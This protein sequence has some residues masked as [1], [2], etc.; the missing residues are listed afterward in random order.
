MEVTS[1]NTAVGFDS[2]Q[3]IGDA[4]KLLKQDFW[5][6][7]LIVAVY[8]VIGFSL[9]LVPLVGGILAWIANGIMFAG[10]IRAITER[11]DG[12]PLTVESV[13]RFF[14][15]GWWKPLAVW[16]VFSGALSLGFTLFVIPGLFILARFSYSFVQYVS[17]PG[18]PNFNP[19]SE[20]MSEL[21]EP[22]KRSYALTA[23]QWFSV[24]VL[25]AASVVVMVGGALCLLVG[26]IPAA[27]LVLIAHVM[28]YRMLLKSYSGQ[29]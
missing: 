18:S 17:Y 5:T 9:N 14:A 6:H 29:G 12:A 23:T 20:G 7:I 1:K 11:I 26:V 10:Y 19:S 22:F 8:A 28:S 3:I 13:F 25:A 21:V 27:S 15:P 2:F 16:I 24:L 4:W